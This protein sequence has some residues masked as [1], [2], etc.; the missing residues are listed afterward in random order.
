MTLPNAVAT[1]GKL[2]VLNVSANNLVGL[3]N[4]LHTLKSLNFFYL[5][6]ND[7]LGI[8]A[9]V[10]K[11]NRPADILEY[12]FRAS[13]GARPLNEA[14]L[15]LVGYGNVG[16]TCLVNRL[17]HNTFRDQ[18]KTEGINIS[19]WFVWV[20]QRED[21]R[22]HVWDFGGKKS[23]TPPIGSFLRRGASICLF[24]VAGRARRTR[25]RN[26]G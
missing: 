26:I 25:T 14:K 17:L 6:G 13:S 18:Q 23:C 7:G 21:V 5:E 4:N 3:P 9:E 8:P 24:S 19:D 22:L 16:K 11:P 2:R 15:I 20:G 1:L 10:L 12:Y